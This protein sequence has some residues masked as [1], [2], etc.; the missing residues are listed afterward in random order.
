MERGGGRHHVRAVA[1]QAAGTCALGT[2][3][4]TACHHDQRVGA[5]DLPC[6]PGV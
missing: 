5:H 2:T 4:R 6:A 3:G 1:C